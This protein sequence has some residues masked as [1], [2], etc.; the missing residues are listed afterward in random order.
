MSTRPGLHHVGL[1][2]IDGDAHAP[3][4]DWV[5]D[6]VPVALAYNGSTHAVMMATPTDLEDYA[7][8]YSLTEGIVAA[9]DPWRLLAIER[10]AH[11]VVLE[12][13]IA[14]ERAEAIDGRRRRLVGSS[15]CG[16]C[17]SATLAEVARPVATVGRSVRTSTAGIAQALSA[18]AERQ[19][20]NHAS[21]GVHAAG[22]CVAG[23]L[24][25]REDVGRHN[26]LDKLVGALALREARPDGVL[27]LTSRASHELLHKAAV[28]GF[29]IVATVSAPTTAAIALA[30]AAGITLVG[31][32]RGARMNVYTH[33][34][35]L[36]E[37]GATGG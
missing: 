36:E 18:L 15:A 3:G 7:R 6:E 23:A 35:R 22:C 37:T 9:G 5:V 25:V 24:L 27:V 1:T 8:G 17:G 31:F 14:P 11:G 28:A 26:A 30:E 19:S 12:M 34:H 29:E 2:R 32:V 16:V 33:G 20:L 10:H 4:A 21:G 13:A